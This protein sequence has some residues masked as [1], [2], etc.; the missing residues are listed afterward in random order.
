MDGPAAVLPSS[1][2]DVA[3]AEAGM[4]ELSPLTLSALPT[5][6]AQHP[7]GDSPSSGSNQ[8]RRTSIQWSIVRLPS[9]STFYSLGPKSSEY[10]KRYKTSIYK[11]LLKILGVFC[12][13][14]ALMLAW[15]ALNSPTKPNDIDIQSLAAMNRSVGSQIAIYQVLQESLG[16]LRE[17]L[18]SERKQL[19]ID[20]ELLRNEESQL[21]LQKWTAQRHFIQ[22][23][24]RYQKVNLLKIQ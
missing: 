1:T 6:A 22:D 16:K 19:E 18:A 24:L 11:N 9:I 20:R 12:G 7:S 23:C 8:S 17:E 14:G 5:D 4:I 2:E 3:Q 10:L 13:L 15:I 21:N